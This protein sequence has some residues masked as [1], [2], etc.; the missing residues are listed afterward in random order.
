M[1]IAETYASG[2]TG[3]S[4]TVEW[5]DETT[6]SFVAWCDDD[7]HAYLI[8]FAGIFKDKDPPPPGWLLDWVTGIGKAI[9]RVIVISNPGP[10]L[11]APVPPAP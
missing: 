4:Y 11:P 10:T 8:G 3:R 1:T 7:G 6:D 5:E 9:V 2:L